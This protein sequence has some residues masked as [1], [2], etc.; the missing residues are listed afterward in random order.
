MS[1]LIEKNKH[2]LVQS[3]YGTYSFN[4]RKT[5]EQLHH[6]LT[7]YEKITKQHQLTEQK[8][9]KIQR[10]IISLQMSISIINDEIQRLHEE[11]IQ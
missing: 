9:D 3:E 8:L 2:Y 6:H 1:E 4:N 7:Q 11:V 5:A 10:T